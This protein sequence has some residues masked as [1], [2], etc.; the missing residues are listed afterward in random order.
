MS[1]LPWPWQWLSGA[2]RI[3]SARLQERRTGKSGGDLSVAQG[4]VKVKRR[5]ASIILLEV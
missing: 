1:E 3:T 2:L 5:T 4:N